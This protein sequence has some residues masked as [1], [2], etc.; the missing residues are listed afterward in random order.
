[1]CRSNLDLWDWGIRPREVVF[2]FAEP[3][4]DDLYQI[5]VLGTGPSALAEYC[6]RGIR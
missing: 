5:D 4:P 2:R 3:L 6:R 1:M